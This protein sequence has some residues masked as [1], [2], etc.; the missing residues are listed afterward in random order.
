M[1]LSVTN[2]PWGWQL[3]KDRSFNTHKISLPTDTTLYLS[4]DG[5]K[6]QFGYA[7]GKRYGSKRL[8]GLMKELVKLPIK[9]QR[10]KIEEEF[11][12]WK[13]I[14]EQTDDVCVMGIKL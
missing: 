12:L 1:K 14:E 3:E 4:S 6:D 11:S 5:F 13:G 8:K 7:S 10:T 9:Q 2:T